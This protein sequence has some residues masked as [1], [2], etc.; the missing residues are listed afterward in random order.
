MGHEIIDLHSWFQTPAGRYL[1]DWEIRQ[2]DS[3]VSNVF[4]YHALQLGLAPL[5]ALAANRMPHQ[6]LALEQAVPSGCKPA[7]SVALQTHF[8]A[9][10]FPSSS[11]DLVVLPHT[12]E[13]TDDPHSTLR[14]VERVL[15]PEG[16]VVIIGLNAASLW[17]MRQG[18]ARIYRR[19]LNVDLFLPESGEFIGY[20]RL[21]DW[22]RLLGFDVEHGGF[23]CYRAATNSEVW[24]ARLQWMDRLGARW[25][26]IFGAA[27]F[28]VAVKRVRGMRLLGTAWKAQPARARQSMPVARQEAPRLDGELTD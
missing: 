11:I 17:A 12:L 23:G 24:L 7:R 18:R 1:L 3:A 28:L 26:P 25:W 16:R 4:G 8:S 19:F 2:L 9:L 10:P 27:Y 14:E 5:D 6:W 21:R 15:V 20:W 13:L 22:L